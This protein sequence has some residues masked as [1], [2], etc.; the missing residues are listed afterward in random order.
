MILAL[1]VNTPLS[2]V[3]A[4]RLSVWLA[5]EAVQVPAT[6]CVKVPPDRLVVPAVAR[7]CAAEMFSV[8]V[9]FAVTDK[10]PADPVMI[11]SSSASVR[12]SSPAASAAPISTLRLV[13]EVAIVAVPPFS[14]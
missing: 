7:V 4:A 2:A 10:I 1:S 14:V 3:V 6:A 12:P 13:D 8:P 5:A 9:P 11:R